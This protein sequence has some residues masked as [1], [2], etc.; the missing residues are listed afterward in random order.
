MPAVELWSGRWK[1][2]SIAVTGSACTI[3]SDPE[4]A[5]IALDDSAV[6]AV[7]I[8]LER[9]GKT[10]LVRDLG[11]RNGTRINGQWLDRQRRIRDGEEI[12]IGHTR[13][14]FRD[15]AEDRRP[16][17]DVLQ[18]PPARLTDKEMEVIKALCRPLL[19]HDTFQ[20]PA[21]VREIAA[22]VCT[23]TN[24]VQAHLTN[25]Y[26]KFDIHDEEGLN[27]RVVLANEAIKRGVIRINDLEEPND[28][29]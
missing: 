28:S 23:G 3:G 6:S 16:K 21:T 10:W 26:R 1:D 8:I 11:S 12:H 20:P 19:R 9:V 25:L 17:T 22:R 24:A 5:D 27:K 15:A 4:S 7:H 18:A 13:L 2:G 29:A 14:V